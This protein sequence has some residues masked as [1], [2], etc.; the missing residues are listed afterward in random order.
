[1][2]KYAHHIYQLDARFAN[3]LEQYARFQWSANNHLKYL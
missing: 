2:A 1:M 3:K